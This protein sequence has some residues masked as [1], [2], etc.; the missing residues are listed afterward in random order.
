[1][2]NKLQRILNIPKQFLITAIF[3]FV[4]INSYFITKEI[5]YQ[6]VL[7]IGLLLGYIAL[8]KPK[9]LL[10]FVGLAAPFS[11]NLNKIKGLEGLGLYFPT[12]PILIGLSL[13]LI[14]SSLRISVLDKKIHSHRISMAVYFMLF[15]LLIT[16]FTSTMPIISVKFLISRLWFVIP[17]YFIATKLFQS[18][19]YIRKFFNVYLFSLAVIIILTVIRHAG[20]GFTQ[21]SGHWVMNPYFKDHTSY[22]AAIAI[23]YPLLMGYS[24]APFKTK[25]PKSV[26]RILLVI[27]SVGLVFSFTRAAWLSLVIGGGVYMIMKLRIKFYWVFTV[28]TL[29]LGSYLYFQHDI[30]RALAKNRQDSSEDFMEH[31]RSM[32]NVSTDASNLERLNRW[33]SALS[34]FTEKPFFGWGPGTYM[35]Q[36]APFQKSKDLT[37]ISTNLGDAGNAH[38]EYIGPM[39]ESGILGLIYFLMILIT[40]LYT[41]IKLYYIIDDKEL[42]MLVMAAIIGI[43]SYAA[44]GF[45]NNFLDT[46]KLSYPF[47]GLCAVIASIDLFHRTIFSSTNENNLEEVKGL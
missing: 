17:L 24:F 38:S 31:I 34:M 22:G 16:T 43:V 5:Y 47:W 1:M 30:A 27:F 2:K 28:F 23:L 15:W 44:H 45:L 10:L 46:D 12:E 6:L 36:Y 3:L 41:G 21:Q 19:E 8:N 20:F 25:I 37:I 18:K 42:K 4:A 35:F 14:I 7:P 40:V 33:N 32:T 11:L 13:L 26:Y 9:L 29:L 39:A